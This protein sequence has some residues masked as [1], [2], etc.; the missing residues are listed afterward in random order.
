MALAARCLISPFLEQRLSTVFMH[1]EIVWYSAKQTFTSHPRQNNI[2]E[3]HPDT[4]Q[5]QPRGLALYRNMQVIL[6]LVCE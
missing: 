3:Q 2:S 1:P 5:L 6:H 4:I